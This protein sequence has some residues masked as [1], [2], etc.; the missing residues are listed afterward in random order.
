MLIAQQA[1][2]LR[3]LQAQKINNSASSPITRLPSAGAASPTLLPNPPINSAIMT[4]HSPLRLLT[5]E[6]THFPGLAAYE[7]YLTLTAR[8]SAPAEAL[9]ALLGDAQAGVAPKMT[10][11]SH[12]AVERSP[13]SL[14]AGVGKVVDISSMDFPAY[15]EDLAQLILP[16]PGLQPFATVAHEYTDLDNSDRLGFGGGIRWN[17]TSSINFGTQ[18]VFFPADQ[19][20]DTEGISRREEVQV[21]TRLEIN[22]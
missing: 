1:G 18:A 3:T 7:Q 22:F 4:F 14:W 8:A 11:S 13:W 19:A 12:W 5:L 21:L 16:F 20:S 10:L 6:M 2:R 9:P 15:Q 17:L